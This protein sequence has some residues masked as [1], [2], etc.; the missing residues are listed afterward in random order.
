MCLFPGFSISLIFIKVLVVL[1][2]GL[3]SAPNYLSADE[4]YKKHSFLWDEEND[5]FSQG[6]EFF[7]TLVLLEGKTYLFSNE[8]ISGP[9]L[10]IGDI[11]GSIYQ[12]D[13]E[14]YNNGV[15]GTSQYCFFKPNK[16]TPRQLFYYPE[17][18]PDKNG[19]IFIEPYLKTSLLFPQVLNVPSSS[20]TVSGGQSDSPYFQFKDGN[21]QPVDFSSLQLSPGHVYEFIAESISTNH[22][23][24]IGETYGDISSSM[25]EGGA[26]TTDGQK[27]T[28]TIPYGYDGDLFYFCTNHSSMVEQFLISENLEGSSFGYSLFIDGNGSVLA[29]SPGYNGMEG[30]VSLIK[31]N[32]EDFSLSHY[33]SLPSSFGDVRA[34][35]GTSLSSYNDW[36]FVGATDYD[37]F[38]GS[39]S[40]HKFNEFGELAI[41]P[42]QTILQSNQSPGFLYGWDIVSTASKFAVSA[43]NIGS[44]DGGK[45]QLFEYADDSFELMRE[46]SEPSDDLGNLFGY[47]MFMNNEY[48]IIGSPEG[49]INKGGTAHIFQ[50]TDINTDSINL[51]PSEVFEG[52]RFGHSVA[53][54]DNYFIVGAPFDDTYATDG[55]AVYIFEKNQSEILHIETIYGDSFSEG[56]HF[57]TQLFV[58]K[59]HLFVLSSSTGLPPVCSVYS[60]FKDNDTNSTVVS[61]VS[62]ISL[63]SVVHDESLDP[64]SQSLVVSDGMVLIGFPQAKTPSGSKTGVV[65]GF[66]NSIWKL[67]S[68]VTVPPIFLDDNATLLTGLED[69]VPVAYLF[70]AIHPT[71]QPITWEINSSNSEVLD[72]DLNSTTGRFQ[73]VHPQ[74]FNGTSSF[75]LKI[76]ADDHEIFHSFDVLIEG[77]NDPPFFAEDNYTSLIGTQGQNFYYQIQVSDIDSPTIAISADSLPQG[78]YID[79]ND[80]SIRGVPESDGNSTVSILASDFEKNSTL[81]LNII[82]Y[83]ANNNPVA[84]FNNQPG[85]TEIDLTL[86]E[87]FSRE[88]WQSAIQSFQILDSDAEQSIYMSIVEHPNNGVLR[89][90]EIFEEPNDINYYPFLNFFGQDTFKVKFF[91]NHIS[92]NLEITVEFN[93][94]IEPVNDLPTVESFQTSFNL[95]LNELFLYDFIVSDSEND[96]VFIT[97]DSL[98]SWITFDGLRTISGV[99]Q[100][101]DYQ[102]L[103]EFDLFVNFTDSNG[104]K[105]T[106]VSHITLIPDISPPAIDS[107]SPISIS[108]QEDETFEG[109]LSCIFEGDPSTLLWSLFDFADFGTVDIQASGKS[110]TFQYVPDS[111]FSG[112]D[113]FSLKVEDLSN[114]DLYDLID[115]NVVINPVEDP[116]IFE[117]QFYSGIILGEPWQFTV[118][119]Y[120]ADPEDFLTLVRRFPAEVPDWWISVSKTSD[121]SWVLSGT[122]NSSND[123]HLNLSLSDGTFEIEKNL[124]LSVIDDPGAINIVHS[125]TNL[126][127]EINED[128]S[129]YIEDGISVNNGESLGTHWSFITPANNGTFTFQQTTYGELN[130]IKYQPNPNFF[131]D[132]K[133]VLQASN[134][135]TSDTLELNFTINSIQDR[136]IFN[137]FPSSTVSDPNENYTIEFSII[138]GDGVDSLV[139]EF[140]ELPEWLE[141]TNEDDLGIQKFL[142]LEGSPDTDQIGL[143]SVRILASGLDDNL[144]SEQNFSILVSYGNKPPVPNSNSLSFEIEEDTSYL[145]NQVLLADDNETPSNQLVWMILEQPENGR[146]YVDSDGSNLRFVPE[147]NSSLSENFVIGV[148]DNG[149]GNFVPRT[150]EI[151][152]TVNI[153]EVD[154]PLIFISEPTSDVEDKYEWNDESSYIYD[155]H[156]Y[157]SDWPWQG[158]ANVKLKTPLPSWAK[159][160]ILGEGKARLSGNPDYDDVGLYHFKIEASG[161]LET[162]VQDFQLR[163]RV[164]DY[165]PIFYTDSISTPL[166]SLSVTILEDM[167]QGEVDDL[168]EG[169]K[170]SNKDFNESTDSMMD[171]LIDEQPTSGAQISDFNYTR[172]NELAEVVTFK[173]IPVTHFSGIDYFTLK[174]TE[175]DRYSLLPVEVIIKPVPDP[176]FFDS[177]TVDQFTILNGTNFE[178][179]FKAY[180][181]DRQKLKFHLKNLTSYPSW[182][183]KKSEYSSNEF[184][185]VVVGGT[186]P[187]NGDVFTYNL[188]VSDP[189]GRW[190]AKVITLQK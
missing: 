29:G 168:L 166:K 86:S 174:V 38:R 42:F 46:F 136:P 120:D 178:F 121:R 60:I 55:G 76:T 118:T 16:N 44:A 142:T 161:P 37:S 71:N 34:Q 15:L 133:V 77:V 101:S 131:G 24:M 13:G 116:P 148:R 11:N 47:D 177:S 23:F 151:S 83:P 110:V 20:F 32:S 1:A 4:T 12:R 5:S 43:L 175:G 95:N 68:P 159:W 171:W 63:D 112:T 141:I 189:T 158:Y 91:D 88:S 33:S 84:S 138:D 25:V 70:D 130:D 31:Q 48:L 50:V 154:D 64:F 115:I 79:E 9:R 94:V 152:V 184:S 113:G 179:E 137:N 143:H 188:L 147:N 180:D 183:S 97:F 61:L 17:G 128:E 22:S 129:W 144:S 21:N 111:N 108:L 163:I 74:D 39:V 78:L 41:T 150:S 102:V 157:D 167:H 126:N 145:Y 87:D 190:S 122:P 65:Q 181:P 28:L 155:V 51:I 92:S 107:I 134:G 40:I 7:P 66:Y 99:P 169:L 100:K 82:I 132:D 35:L 125:L 123:V 173:Y 54:M 182:L 72:F 3:Y 52:D 93:L 18:N 140:T 36:L 176:P 186:V 8:S 127:I 2:S 105:L 27:I 53:V 149:Y 96:E 14:I 165:P 114:S 73:F 172:G 103:N 170:V 146:A 10:L 164:D 62:Q 90:S 67:L 80:S 98:P 135:Y 85:I 119:G 117:N 153:S 162:V 109:N 160:E 26:L 156:A 59:K 106:K 6:G 58:D 187:H 104:G 56:Y 139:Y 89:I 69:S 19:S 124:T 75:T 81:I 45:V 185:T 30:L 57:G 49:G